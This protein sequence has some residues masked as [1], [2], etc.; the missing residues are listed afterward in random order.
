MGKELGGGEWDMLVKLLIAVVLAV[1]IAVIKVLSL[2]MS[3]EIVGDIELGRWAICSYQM[4]KRNILSRVE[5]V[6]LIKSVA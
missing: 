6:D 3:Q 2:F 5:S 4:I 1:V